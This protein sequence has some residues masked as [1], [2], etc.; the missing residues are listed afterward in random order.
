M[1]HFRQVSLFTSFYSLCYA[2]KCRQLDAGIAG[3]IVECIYIMKRLARYVQGTK[4]VFGIMS[5]QNP[6]Q[7]VLKKTSDCL[8]RPKGTDHFKTPCHACEKHADSHCAA[9][10]DIYGCE[11]LGKGGEGVKAPQ[12]KRKYKCVESPSTLTTLLWCLIQSLLL[13]SFLELA[14]LLE[15]LGFLSY[16]V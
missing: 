6:N 13:S 2:Q 7:V 3:K 8:Y 12:R 14:F 11:D 10:L 5:Q 9:E 4:S 1:Y 15:K 16:C